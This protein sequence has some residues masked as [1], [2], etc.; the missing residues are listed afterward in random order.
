MK[1]ALFDFD[2]TITTKDTLFEFCRF[3]AGKLKFLAGL[4][5][6]A[7]VLVLQRLQ[8]IPAQRAKE[9]VLAYFVGGMVHAQFRNLC[10][11]FAKERVPALLRPQAQEAMAT[12]TTNH[13]RILIVSASP[14]D[15]IKPWAHRVGAEVLATRLQVVEGKISGKIEGKNCN[16]VEKVARIKS[17]V[18]LAAAT[19]IYAY[20]DSRGD[21]PMLA[22]AQ[23]KYFK[24][25]R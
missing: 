18:N 5:W 21:L 4:V 6:L 1:L 2:G 7:P 17:E 19:Y 20:G 3:K 24:P 23:E 14:E 10:I 11:A 13:V 15:W 16:G 25:F 9:I 8:L 12:H 22:L